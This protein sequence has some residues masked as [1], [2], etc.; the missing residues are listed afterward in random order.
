MSLSFFVLPHH[1]RDHKAE[2]GAT[3]RNDTCSVH[4]RLPGRKTR[5]N[6]FKKQTDITDTTL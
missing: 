6:I 4:G 3:S 2:G 5:I 1:R